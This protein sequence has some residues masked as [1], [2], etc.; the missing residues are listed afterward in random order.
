LFVKL[1]DGITQERRDE[2]ANG[3]RSFFK[4]SAT[5]LLDMDATVATV[6]NI[7]SIFQIFVAVVGAIALILA[8]FLLLISTT[9]NIKENVWEYGCLRAMGFT[10]A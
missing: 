6:D 10:K 4:D 1:E 9:Q 8:F 5:F 7:L 3:I 2:I